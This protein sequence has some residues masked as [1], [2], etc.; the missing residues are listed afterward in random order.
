MAEPG[1]ARRSS[2]RD[3]APKIENHGN[4]KLKITGIKN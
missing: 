4:F 1:L 3:Q 2:G